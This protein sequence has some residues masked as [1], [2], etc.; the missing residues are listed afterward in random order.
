MTNGTITRKAVE[1]LT[2]IRDSGAT[3]MFAM[4]TV[5][6]IANEREMYELV[7]VIEDEGTSGYADLLEEVGR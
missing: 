3:N 2:D 6:R 4:N 5:Q 1:Q 7:I